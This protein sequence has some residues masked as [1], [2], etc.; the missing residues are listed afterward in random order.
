[1]RPRTGRRGSWDDLGGRR[2][3][4]A[5]RSAR[6][7]GCRATPHQ[8]PRP[9]APPPSPAALLKPEP[10]QKSPDRPATPAE[11]DDLLAA[12]DAEPVVA[13]DVFLRRVTLDLTGRLPTADE[14]AAFVA[15]TDADKRAKAVDRLLASDA[16]AGRW[17]RHWA[18][19]IAARVSPYM[20]RLAP[21]LEEWL[22]DQI[23]NGRG[24]DGIVRDMLTA[25][26][27]LTDTARKAGEVGPGQ[28]RNG[29]AFFIATRFYEKTRTEGAIDAAAEPARPTAGPAA[30]F[31]KE[32]EFD[33]SARPERTLPQAL[34]LMNSPF[35]H[36]GLRAGQ[37]KAL[38]AA[39][40]SPDAA[41]G[42]GLLYV[43]TLGRRPTAREVEIAAKYL[44]GS[45]T[46]AEGYEDLLWALVNTPEFLNSR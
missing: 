31:Q 1:M 4:R 44:R 7:G 39:A 25:D 23:R 10:W 38:T 35:V 21:V 37:S 42:V 6:R 30:A 43:H 9:A 36:N 40:K 22:A 16:F 17:A 32:F 27:A 14:L 3:G 8:P 5:S 28:P 24:W 18:D 20:Q 34:W 33:P 41:A 2:V 12:G 45:K 15:S 29:A 11:I 46:P 26:A 13:D 19:A